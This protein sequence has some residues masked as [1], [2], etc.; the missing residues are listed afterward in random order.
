MLLNKESDRTI[1]H[2]TFLS[3]GQSNHITALK[4]NSNQ[5]E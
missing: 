5:A 1:S 2:S 3:L 4:Q